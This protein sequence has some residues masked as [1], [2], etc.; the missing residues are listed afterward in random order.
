MATK[1]EAARSAFSLHTKSAS[2]ACTDYLRDQI[3][4]GD[5]VNGAALVIDRIAAELDISH[6]PVREAVRRLEAEGLVTYE[7]RRGVKVRG[8]NPSE[9]EEL[10]GLRKALEPIAL[11]KAITLAVPGTFVKAE[12]ELEIWSKASGSREMLSRQR[13]FLRAMY[14]PSGLTRTL[15]V[16]DANLRLIERYHQRSWKTSK[17]VHDKD[18]QLKK[19]ILLECRARNAKEAVASLIRAIEWG[20]SI[21]REKL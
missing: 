16:I 9:F 19:K 5:L 7:P 2:D 1:F 11:E 12:K 13:S 8:L 3:I 20:A 18:L 21:A 4:C 14:E 15:E 6:T 17:S 10:V